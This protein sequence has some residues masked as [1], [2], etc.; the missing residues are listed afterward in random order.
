MS[1]LL[2]PTDA[3]AP[4]AEPARTRVSVLRAYLPIL[5]T[6]AILALVPLRYSD[7]RTMMG[8]AIGGLLFAA[9]AV[10]FN[11]IF[12]CSGQLFLCVGALAGV[13]VDR[14]WRRA[15]VGVAQV[16]AG[17]DGARAAEHHCHCRDPAESRHIGVR[18]IR[19]P[20]GHQFLASGNRF[21]VLASI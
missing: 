5:V 7:S 19:E 17:V 16:V 20:L 6:A 18:P 21:R 8:V 2:V 9:Y 13:G 3:P 11:V 1:E 10:S 14:R 4:T 15:T 12:G